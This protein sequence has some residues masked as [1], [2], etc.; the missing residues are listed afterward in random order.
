[1]VKVEES[2]WDRIRDSKNPYN[3]RLKMV[4]F[5]LESRNYSLTAKAF[6]TS[7]QSVK[8]WVSRY[9][10]RG[11]EGLK[12]KKRGPRISPRRTPKEVEE[13]VIGYRKTFKTIGQERIRLMLLKD[14]NISLSTRTINR[15]LNAHNLI[16]KRK[17]KPH[18][19][20]TSKRYQF[21][22]RCPK[23]GFS[24]ISFGYSNDSINAGVFAAY[25]YSRLSALVNFV[26][27][28]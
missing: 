25:V 2:Y 3:L 16:Q 20:R 26:L 5:Y 24:I 27:T 6:K 8:K 12:S 18:R 4:R 9:L 7:R 14:H 22:A 11:L 15:I 28:R 17:K 23:T 19:K 1:M 21:T 10:E 13:L